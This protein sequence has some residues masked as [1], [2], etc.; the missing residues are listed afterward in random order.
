MSLKKKQT[1]T[2]WLFTAA[3]VALAM[4]AVMAVRP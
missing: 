4:C 3:Y 2:W 1:L